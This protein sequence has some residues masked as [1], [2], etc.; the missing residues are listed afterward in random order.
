[1]LPH[2]S[3]IGAYIKPVIGIVPLDNAAGTRTGAAI[4]TRGYGSFTLIGFVGAASGTPD[5]QSATYSIETSADGVNN[6]AAVA[7]AACSAITADDSSAEVDVDCVK[8]L[9]YVR[10]SEVVAFTGGTTPKVE[11]AAV[12]VLGGATDLPA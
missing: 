4:D 3:N 8:T 6:W 9:R 2:K 1:M 10:V 12:V 11:G 5:T 7:G